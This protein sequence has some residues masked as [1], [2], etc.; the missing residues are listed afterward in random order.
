MKKQIPIP[1][2][3]YADTECLL[4]RINIDEGKCTNYIKSTFLILQ[5][6]SQFVLITSLLYQ[7][8]FFEG[9][10][11]I[12]KF[13]KWIFRAQKYCNQIINNCFDKNDYR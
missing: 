1:F 10:N 13:I 5:E 6:Q 8:L 11:C 12:N 7:L 4:K 3:I 9:K 2:K